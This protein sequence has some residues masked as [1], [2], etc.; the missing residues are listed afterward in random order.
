MEPLKTFDN[1]NMAF[2]YYTA[3]YSISPVDAMKYIDENWDKT[4]GDGQ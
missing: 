2:L 4:R 1:K 3:I